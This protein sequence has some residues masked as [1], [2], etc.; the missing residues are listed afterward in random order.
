LTNEFGSTILINMGGA[1]I[2]KIAAVVSSVLLAGSY[3]C[4]QAGC[5]Q[6][7]FG[8]SQPAAQSAAGRQG[9]PRVLLSGSKSRMIGP[10]VAQASTKPIPQPASPWMLMAGSK[11][12]AIGPSVFS[13]PLVLNSTK[14]PLTSVAEIPDSKAS[15]I[16]ER[17]SQPIQ[18]D[19]LMVSSKSGPVI[20]PQ[21]MAAMSNPDFLKNTKAII[22]VGPAGALPMPAA[23]QISII[24]A[25]TTQPKPV[26]TSQPAGL[27]K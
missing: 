1:H 16:V 10:T 20:T 18:L 8:K 15:I 5:I 14:P 6:L 2:G 4:Y 25:P 21:Q 12:A 3:V 11:S 22:P 13:E 24:S 23:N 19:A 7:P 9:E 27:N 26:P 17:P